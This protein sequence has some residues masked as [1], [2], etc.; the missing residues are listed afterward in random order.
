MAAYCE[1]D[2]PADD[3]RMR[4]AFAA[5]EALLTAHRP[6]EVPDL[7]R[8]VEAAARAGRWAFGFV[9]YE[10]AG[11][12]DRALATHAPD[13]PL[14]CFAL[15]ESPAPSPRT[16]GEWLSGVWR[17]S[18]SPSA[19]DAAVA[20]IKAGIARGDYY[21]VN[22]TTRLQA[23][24]FGDSLAFFDALR[25]QQAAGYCAYLEFGRWRVCS[26][27]PELFFH[28]RPDAGVLCSKP[29]KGTAPRV[30][31][32]EQDAVLRASLARSAKDR[33]EN[34]MI[35]D[36]IRNDLSRVAELGS[37]SVPELFA[38]EDWPTVWQMTSTVACRPRTGTGLAEIFAA[39]F[40]CG[41]V[42]GA[43]KAAAMA[44]IARL[45]AAPR[46]AYCGA[47]GIV[48]PGGE[49]VF[50][51]GIRTVVVDGERGSAECGIGSG[52]VI[53]STAAGESA[54][55]QV[56]QVF[57]RRALPT[58]ALI[59]TLRLHR[60]RYWLRRGHLAR[61]A[62][63]AAALGFSFERSR[64]D[65]ALDAAAQAHADG[66]WRL[67]L[68]LAPDGAVGVEI[69]PLEATPTEAE[70]ALAAVPV[71]SGNPWLAY[72]TDRRGIY[73]I[74]AS[75]QAGIFDTLLYN[76]RGEA[77]EFTRG[78]LMAEIDGRRLTPPTACG[79]LPGVLRQA[80]LA[81]RR[82]EEGVVSLDA[83]ARAS[84]LWFVNSVRGIVPVRLR[85]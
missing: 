51:V 44:A 50:N 57:L 53:D 67:R 52:I 36:L 60:G 4:G 47:I 18:M 10:A 80:L 9:A 15:F 19:F 46:G 27:S 56:K 31:D 70:A 1:V 82:V 61:L 2:F 65:A 5:P 24:L 28:W 85:R 41:S 69:F 43:P 13:M 35:V 6:D 54:E 38:V 62:R 39:L 45:E 29:M 37:V 77:T 11:A 14:A 74:S 8:R 75:T 66:Q 81:S 73:E 78:N 79:L 32:P 25:A 20:A 48:K 7:L 30:A 83:L 76:E 26:T 17:D 34:L 16:R 40:P 63:S 49:A 59:E 12:F 58:Y 71:A 64:V 84:R 55:W 33:A 21:Q 22:L 68:R 72:K 42:T 3:G 23:P